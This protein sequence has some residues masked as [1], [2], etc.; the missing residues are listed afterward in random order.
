LIDDHKMIVDGIIQILSKH[1]KFEI[2]GYSLTGADAVKEA[3]KSG[4]ID[5]FI[6]DINLPDLD[7]LEVINILKNFF[8]GSRFIILSMHNNK[9]II[10]NAFQTGIIAYVLKNSGEDQ[11]IEAILNAMDGK[12]YVSKDLVGNLADNLNDEDENSPAILT[13]REITIAKLTAKGLTSNEVAAIL[14]ISPRTVETHRRNI[15]HK[16]GFKN[17]SELIKYAIQSAWIDIDN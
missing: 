1:H 6:T 14:F 8:P 15:M 11:L 5:V 3:Q 7:G 16:L 12:K 2:A 17:H 4:K 9:N 13:D 10:K